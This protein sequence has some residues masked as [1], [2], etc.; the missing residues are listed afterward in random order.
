MNNV[1]LVRNVTTNSGTVLSIPD[2][3]M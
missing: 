2:E 1:M 3:W